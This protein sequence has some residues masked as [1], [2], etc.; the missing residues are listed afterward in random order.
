MINNKAPDGNAGPNPRYFRELVREINRQP[1]GKTASASASPGARGPVCLAGFR[2]LTLEVPS[3]P[4]IC[5]RA[6][7]TRADA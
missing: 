4:R 3:A 7:M 5:D 6:V 1:A 2:V